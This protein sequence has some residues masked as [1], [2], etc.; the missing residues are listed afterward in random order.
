MSSFKVEIMRKIVI[1]SCAFISLLIFDINAQSKVE[2]ISIET[3]QEKNVITAK[4]IVVDFTA[5]WCGWCKKMD[6]TTFSN[7]KVAD[8]LN[9]EFY[10]IKMDFE[11]TIKFSFDGKQYT[12][13]SFAKKA[14]IEGLPTMVVVSS[15]YKTFDIISGYQKPKP[16]LKEL[17]RYR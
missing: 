7:P 17:D 6:A 1:L 9:Q 16:F 5:D 8:V 3:A 4:Y 12:A 11:S 13:K 15:D 14:G 10:A 2:W